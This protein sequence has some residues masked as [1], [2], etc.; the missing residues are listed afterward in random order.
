ML[1]RFI[2]FFPFQIRNTEQNFLLVN[3]IVSEVSLSLLAMPIDL[4]N[5]I[6]RGGLLDS[7]VCPLVGFMHTFFG[8]LLR[9]DIHTNYISRI[10]IHIFINTFFGN[11]IS[12]DYSV[13]V[14]YILW[15]FTHETIYFWI[16]S[17]K[18]NNNNWLRRL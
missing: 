18:R 17:R 13:W 6:T 1:H 14:F 2:L 12:C 10:V 7:F 3:L 15:E 16:Y 8:K 9:F 11:F 4:Y 5:S